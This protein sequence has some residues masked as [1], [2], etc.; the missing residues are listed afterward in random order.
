M[1]KF[2]KRWSFIHFT[3]RLKQSSDKLIKKHEAPNV[4]SVVSGDVF[5][6]E[7]SRLHPSGAQEFLDPGGPADPG[8]VD[9]AAGEAAVVGILSLL[10]G[11]AQQRRDQKVPIQ[12]ADGANLGKM[13]DS[14]P[15]PKRHVSTISSPWFIAYFQA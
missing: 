3:C 5:H 2:I 10:E 12:R 13:E 7:K 1:K 14:A 4:H 6:L 15:R 9:G 11:D 8:Q